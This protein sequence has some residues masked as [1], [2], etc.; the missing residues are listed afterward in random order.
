[1]QLFEKQKVSNSYDLDI[2]DYKYWGVEIEK[3]GNKILVIFVIY[4]D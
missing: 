3:Q 4:N 1:M 2:W